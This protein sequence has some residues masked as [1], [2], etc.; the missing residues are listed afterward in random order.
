M[1][2]RMTVAIGFPTLPEYAPEQSDDYAVY[3]LMVDTK[4]AAELTR[5]V[6]KKNTFTRYIERIYLSNGR[7]ED[8]PDVSFDDGD[9]TEEFDPIVARK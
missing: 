8:E 3:Y 4:G 6:V 9:A 2:G 5:P 1:N 7:P